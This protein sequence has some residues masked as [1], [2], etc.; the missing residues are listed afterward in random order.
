[1]RAKLDLNDL[2]PDSDGNYPD[3]T[4]RDN[5]ASSSDGS[6][7]VYFRNLTDHLKEHIAESDAVFGCVAW[8]TH[9]DIL[10]ALASRQT[11][12]IVQK[13]DFLRPDLGAKSNWKNQLRAKYRAMG[14]DLM[15]F[16]FDNMMGSL[17]TCSDPSIEPVRCVGNFNREKAP[18]F[19]RMHNKFLVFARIAD[20]DQTSVPV[21]Y[22]VWTGSF[23]LTANAAASLE[24]ALY[25]T[26]PEIVRAYF[27]EF[28]QIMALSEPLDWESDWSAPDLRIGT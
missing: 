11:A 23:N 21:P 13:E 19:P 8:L 24:N 20:Q 5:S 12:I 6:V 18:A 16:A 2:C 26:H 28:G 25:I 7:R 10:D 9:F 1:M 27:E 4:P 17:S 14:C 3:V 15:R 22:A